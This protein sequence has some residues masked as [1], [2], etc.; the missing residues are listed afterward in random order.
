MKALFLILSIILISEYN[1]EACAS[2]NPP[3]DKKE[4]LKRN[5]GDDDDFCCL[6]QLNYTNGDTET[7]CIPLTDKN[8]RKMKDF[9]RDQID[10]KQK[11]K[12]EN[13]TFANIDCGAN[14]LIISILSLIIL[15]L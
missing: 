13:I 6:F 9:L 5:L 14:Y 10:N 1:C 11:E 15:F 3:K 4:C 12:K 8:H 7:N 2:K